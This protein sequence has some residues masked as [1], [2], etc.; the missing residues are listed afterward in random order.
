MSTVA[1]DAVTFSY[2]ESDPTLRDV[3]ASIEA[4]DLVLVIGDSGAGK[5]T[6]LRTVNGLVPHS[7]GGHLRGEV[8]TAGLTVSTSRPKDFAGIVG[9]LHQDPESHFVVDR[10]DLDIAFGPENLGLEPSEIRRRV[11]EVCDALGIAHLRDRRPASLSGGEQQR[12]AIAGVLATG[13]RILVLDEP[14]SQL[15]PQGAEDVLAAVARLNTDLGTTILVAEHRLERVAPLSDR[16]IHLRAGRVIEHGEPSDVLAHYEGAPSVTRLGLLLGWRPPPLTVKDAQRLARSVELP[17]PPAATGAVAGEAI[18][19]A[20]NVAVALGGR[21]AVRDVDLTVREGDV[22]AVLGRNGAG[23]TTLLRAL[24]GLVEISRGS[25]DRSG[26]VAYVP[27]DPNSL[28]FATSV[29][30]ELNQTLKLLGR[31]D[32]DL[33]DAWI[34][35]LRLGGVADRHPRTLSGGERQRTAVGAVAIAGAKVL[36][37]DETTRG[38]DAASRAALERAISIHSESGGAVLLATHDV[39]LAARVATRCVVL[40]DGEVIA[41]GPAG[42]VLAGSLFAPQ[43]L[44]VVPPFTTV[45]QV[46][47][48]LERV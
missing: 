29:R 3:T 5:S 21:P 10:V 9:F 31:R 24:A 47:A 19:E 35:R 6:L 30:D 37:L 43:V 44:R 41:S 26:P 23:K 16:V 25:I 27:Q 12:C 32:P 36:A 18:V 42:E 7:S 20:R 28:L 17:S 45:E 34:E 39:E 22:I 14:T 1:F 46:A 33:A 8:T 38:M 40:A 48:A 11:E 15:D 2:P 4:G 13:P